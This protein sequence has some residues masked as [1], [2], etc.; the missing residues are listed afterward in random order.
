MFVHVFVKQGGHSFEQKFSKSSGSVKSQKQ[1]S[2]EENDV[3]SNMMFESLIFV[4]AFPRVP[5]L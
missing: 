1:L 5:V 4:M 3:N 2:C